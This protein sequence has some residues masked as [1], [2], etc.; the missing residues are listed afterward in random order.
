M[1]IIFGAGNFGSQAIEYF[2][3]DNVAYFADNN[4]NR[5]GD[6]YCDKEIISPKKCIEKSK[7]YRI[8]VSVNAFKDITAMLREEGIFDYDFFIPYRQ[9][10]LQE[11]TNAVAGKPFSILGTDDETEILVQRLLSN[12]KARGDI[13][14]YDT[15]L[16]GNVGNDYHG[17][18]VLPED[19][20]P[21][22]N[23]ILVGAPSRAYALQVHCERQYAGREICNPFIQRYYAAP[24]VWIFK[25]EEPEFDEEALIA[26][27]RSRASKNIVDEYMYELEVSKPLFNHIEVETVN[28]CNGVCSFCPVSANHERREFAKMDE[29]LYYRIVDQLAGMNYSGRFAPFSNNEPFLDER[30]ADFLK[31]ARK[32][33][34]NARIHLFS[35]GTVLSVDTF[36]KAVEYLDELYID[37]Y[38]QQMQL[39]PP[40]RKI[41]DYCDEHEE[42]KK[43]VTI[44]IRKP[45]E[46]RTS[47]GGDAPNRTR[48]EVIPEIG[49]VLPFS[50]LIIRPDGKVSLCCNDPYGKY[51]LGDVNTESLVDIWYGERFNKV[52]K[53]MFKG[54]ASWGECRYCDTVLY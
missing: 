7:D 35:N 12:G 18:T 21:S 37:N 8:I 50:Q 3:A 53:A 22:D 4:S 10:S 6:I 47:R 54:R 27:S 19:E 16:S 40:I 2:G 48:Q 14:L 42:L 51:T 31:Y 52:R 29:A 25:A 49:C 26:Q 11:L 34:P 43:K 44:C 38:N 36:A 5:W 30:V 41:A 45:Q 15:D 39:I 9:E 1:I 24:D 20:I 13:H 28:R 17:F 33:L 46:V 32:K 23:V